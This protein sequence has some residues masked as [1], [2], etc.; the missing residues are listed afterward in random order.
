MNEIVIDGVIGSWEVDAKEI[1]SELN[2]MTGDV[3]EKLN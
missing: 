1:V 2:N 3:T